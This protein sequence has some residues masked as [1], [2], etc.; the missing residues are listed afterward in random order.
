MR[1]RV[2]SPVPCPVSSSAPARLSIQA[3]LTPELKTQTEVARARTLGGTPPR[4][5]LFLSNL[6]WQAVHS[7]AWLVY[8]Y[9]TSVVP[10]RRGRVTGKAGRQR[11]MM[12]G[13]MVCGWCMDGWMDDDRPQAAHSQSDHT[14]TPPP[15][16]HMA[17]RASPNLTSIHPDSERLGVRRCGTH[18]YHTAGHLP[19]LGQALCVLSAQLV[20]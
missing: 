14:Q 9:L 5:F 2:C 4:F 8:V 7:F 10:V 11:L 16:T 3:A 13:W 6:A 15:P 12:D 19:R 18:T 20:Q 1:M 17:R